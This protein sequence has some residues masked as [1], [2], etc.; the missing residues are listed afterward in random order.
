MRNKKIKEKPY[1]RV[2]SR[3][4]IYYAA[5]TNE[6]NFQNPQFHPILLKLH[7]LIT[8]LTNLT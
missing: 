8:L 3:I 1:D 5:T 2:H 7:I 6:F 4:T